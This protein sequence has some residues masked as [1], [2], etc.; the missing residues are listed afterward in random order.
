[1]LWPGRGRTH[2]IRAH[3]A[4]IGNPVL[5]DKEWA[6]DVPSLER[7]KKAGLP[8]APRLMLHAYKLTVPHPAT[9]KALRFTAPPPPDF[10]SYWTHVKK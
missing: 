8:P 2:Q 6:G 10:K 3:L 4:H 7:I 5:G 9:G 1:M